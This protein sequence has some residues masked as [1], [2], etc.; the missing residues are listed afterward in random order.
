MQAIAEQWFTEFA[1]DLT[2]VQSTQVSYRYVE[3]INLNNAT[4]AYQHDVTGEV[5]HAGSVGG[6]PCRPWE[7]FVYTKRPQHRYFKVGLFRV[8]GVVEAWVNGFGIDGI[9]DNALEAV[10]VEIGNTLVTVGAASL[11]PIVL[12]RVRV[13]EDPE[14]PFVSYNYS[15]SLVA[16][17]SFRGIGHKVNN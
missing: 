6:E 16:G 14:Q 11:L 3:A 17:V 1:A 9:Y 13:P 8:R 12:R 5:I 2:A 4:E 10:R 15:H 7:A